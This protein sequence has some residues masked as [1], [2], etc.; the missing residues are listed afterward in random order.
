[1]KLYLAGGFRSGWQQRVR[2][3]LPEVELFDPSQHNL[4]DPVEFARWDLDAIRQSDAV[5]AYMEESNPGGYSLALEVG[6]AHALGKQ[7]VLVEEHPNSQR[8]RYFAMVRTVANLRFLTLDEAVSY[9]ATAIT[10]SDTSD[11]VDYSNSLGT[12]FVPNASAARST[13]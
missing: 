10:S 6:F 7:V 4:A 12:A 11:L 2:A 1:M 9:L 8:E 5:L 3:A 13:S